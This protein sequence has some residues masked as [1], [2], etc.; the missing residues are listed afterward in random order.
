MGPKT[1]QNIGYV[2][3]LIDESLREIEVDSEVQSGLTTQATTMPDN[4]N[5]YILYTDTD[6]DVITSSYCS[7]DCNSG[8]LDC[9]VVSNQDCCVCNRYSWSDDYI[10][11]G[12]FTPSSNGIPVPDGFA[13]N[14]PPNGLI[15]L[16]IYSLDITLDDLYEKNNWKDLFRLV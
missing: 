14:T 2:S 12:N 16:Q 10:Y 9:S 8:T 1:S 7:D 15:Q 11:R 13:M 4:A 5:H 6:S 3:C